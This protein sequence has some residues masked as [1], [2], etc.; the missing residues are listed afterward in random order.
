MTERPLTLD[1]LAGFDPFGAHRHDLQRFFELARQSSPV[2]FA[3]K[4]DAW[5][6]TS[7]EDIDRVLRDGEL[8]SCKDHNP[9]PPSTLLPE[10]LDRVRQLEH[11]LNELGSTSKEEG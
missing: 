4:L 1:D 3:P 6:V 8:F 7:Y 10:L 5:C 11:H 2:F 9:R